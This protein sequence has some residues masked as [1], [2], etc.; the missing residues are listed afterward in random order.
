[1]FSRGSIG[2][3]DSQ[4]LMTSRAKPGFESD[5]DRK[6]LSGVTARARGR[7]GSPAVS[8]NSTFVL[9]RPQ[10]TSPE[11]LA[12]MKAADRELNEITT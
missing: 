1:M 8:P 12:G 7:L 2:I 11:Y 9:P 4:S 10:T 5:D 6:N 3:V